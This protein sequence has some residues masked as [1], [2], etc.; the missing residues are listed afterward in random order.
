KSGGVEHGGRFYSQATCH[1]APEIYSGFLAD[2]STALLRQFF[3]E[4]R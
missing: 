1:H 2:E 4:R 3:G